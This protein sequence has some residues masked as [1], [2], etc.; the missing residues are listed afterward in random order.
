MSC[1]VAPVVLGSSSRAS[2]VVMLLRLMSLECVHSEQNVSMIN[3]KIIRNRKPVWRRHSPRKALST[4]VASDL[5]LV[6]DR[7]PQNRL[8]LGQL[9]V[10]DKLAFSPR[11]SGHMSRDIVFAGEDVLTAVVR[12]HV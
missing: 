4:L 8:V 12:L 7:S 11:V 10:R 5:G 3:G 9:P 1:R 2:L 6:L